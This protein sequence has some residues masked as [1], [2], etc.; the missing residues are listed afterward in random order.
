[1][2]FHVL[3]KQVGRC[4]SEGGFGV[5]LPVGPADMVAPCQKTSSGLVFDNTSAVCKQGGTCF[6]EEGEVLG[7]TSTALQQVGT[8]SAGEVFLPRRPLGDTQ[9]VF[10]EGRET[11][12]MPLTGLLAPLCE[13][14]LWLSEAVSDAKGGT[15]SDHKVEALREDGATASQS[16]D[17][18]DDSLTWDDLASMGPRPRAL[19]L[20]RRSTNAIWIWHNT[21]KRNRRGTGFEQDTD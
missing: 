15:I 6:G 2:F 13:D 7:K 16:S 1:M 11:Q 12:A 19:L 21:W 5:Q 3:Q 9:A 4:S 18:G 10:L 8:W 17:L 20:S 14:E